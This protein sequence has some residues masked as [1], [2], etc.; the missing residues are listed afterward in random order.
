[1]Y[2]NKYSSFSSLK[3]FFLIECKN[4]ASEIFVNDLSDL[5]NNE[6]LTGFYK[7]RINY[8]LFYFYINRFIYCLTLFSFKVFKTIIIYENGTYFL[9]NTYGKM[10]SMIDVIH[11]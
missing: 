10:L 6:F 2:Y 5:K 4:L 11:N 9:R 1:M 3:R 7:I 8:N